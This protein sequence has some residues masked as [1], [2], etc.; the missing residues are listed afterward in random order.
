MWQTGRGQ[1]WHL[2]HHRRRSLAVPHLVS[3]T[4][5]Q[6]LR[7]PMTAN[8]QQQQR[9]QQRPA[10]ALQGCCAPL[11]DPVQW[12]LLLLLVSAAA[13]QQCDKV[14][15]GAHALSHTF[16]LRRCHSFS[17]CRH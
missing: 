3:G 8:H 6:L 7:C 4:V 13:E 14:C 5:L 10:Q 16:Q 1:L 15:S 11:P 9:M 2:L 12:D 17:R